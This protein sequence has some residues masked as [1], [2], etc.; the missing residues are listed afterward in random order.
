M[1]TSLFTDAVAKQNAS[2]VNKKNNVQAH[3]ATKNFFSLLNLQFNHEQDG[4]IVSNAYNT[5]FGSKRS[6]IWAQAAYFL[7]STFEDILFN[8]S[9]AISC[10]DF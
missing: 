8:G 10:R 3:V 6:A 7:H 4:R 1:Y 9:Q 5:V 2:S